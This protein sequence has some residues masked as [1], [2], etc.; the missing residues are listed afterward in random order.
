MNQ[1]SL[2]SFA[3]EMDKLAG[4]LPGIGKLSPFQGGALAGGILGATSGKTT[5]NPQTGEAQKPDRFKRALVGGAIGGGGA[6]MA[7]RKGQASTKRFFQR[8]RHGLTGHVPK[9][10]TRIGHLKK[11]D[12][13]GHLWGGMK[14]DAE[15]AKGKGPLGLFGKRNVAG[16]AEQRVEHDARQKAL[17]D[18]ANQGATSLPGA[19]K[20]MVTKPGRYLKQ[21]WRGMD[22]TG[23][24]MAVGLPAYTSYKGLRDKKE[25][26]AEIAGGAAGD[27]AGQAAFMNMPMV[28]GSVLGMGLG[29]AGKK[30]GR[31]VQ[32]RRSDRRDDEPAVRG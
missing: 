30:V 9:G 6:W 15:A 24:A 19:A 21:S 7:S 18:L 5:V 20:M 16:V 1:T 22:T 29:A 13:D 3:S 11:I 4:P 17:R 14:F 2:K 28:G 10:E 8:Q 12:P 31:L 25:S 26:N 32:K 27:L 23:K